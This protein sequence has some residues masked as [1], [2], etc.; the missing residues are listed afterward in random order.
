MSILHTVKVKSASPAK[1]SSVKCSLRSST[2]FVLPTN[3]K[4]IKAQNNRQKVNQVLA[5]L[6]EEVL[7]SLRVDEHK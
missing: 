2:S 6:Q 3:E 1:C 7:Q 5:V 4:Q